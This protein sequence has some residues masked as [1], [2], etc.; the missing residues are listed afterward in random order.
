MILL[1]G[2]TGAL[3]RAIHERVKHGAFLPPDHRALMTMPPH[4]LRSIIKSAKGPIVVNCVAM[5]GLDACYEHVGEAIVV[6]RDFPGRIAAAAEYMD[7]PLIHFSTESVFA[8]D[9]PGKLWAPT[10][11]P[12][13]GTMYGRTK[14][15]GERLAEYHGGKIIRLPLLYGPTNDKQIVAK[16]IDRVLNGE[17]V[18]AAIDVIST[19]VYTPDVAYWLI[20]VFRG[21]RALDPITHLTGPERISLYH[22]VRSI[23]GEL[24]RASLVMPCHASD[25]PSHEPKPLYGGLEGIELPSGIGRYAEYLKARIQ[26]AA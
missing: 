23:A 14:T 21:E 22:L 15:H 2:H 16:L 9:A 26:N 25:F 18:Q 20:P 19:Q 6:N 7:R 1:L 24:G 12:N 4:G 10:D 3:G 17:E 5:T 13:P 11:E 8:C